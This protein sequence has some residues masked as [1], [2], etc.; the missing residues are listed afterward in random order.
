MTTWSAARS[1]ERHWAT[2]PRARGTQWMIEAQKWKPAMLL[3]KQPDGDFITKSLVACP[4]RINA[5][6]ARVT[7]SSLEPIDCIATELGPGF[8]PDDRTKR[9]Q[10]VDWNGPSLSALEA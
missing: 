3:D 9:S 5:M 7:R 4:A 10:S 2:H 8:A 1:R 6:S